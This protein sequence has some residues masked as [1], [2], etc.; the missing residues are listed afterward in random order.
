VLLFLLGCGGGTPH[1]DAYYK[2]Y[3]G[4]PQYPTSSL[5]DL[6]Q[7]TNK[8]SYVIPKNTSHQFEYPRKVYPRRQCFG[9]VNRNGECWGNLK[10][11]PGTEQRCFGEFGGGEC[12]GNTF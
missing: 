7:P 2:K 1:R 4:S 5:D 3:G 9:Y 6:E 12:S 10:E 8:R 11:T